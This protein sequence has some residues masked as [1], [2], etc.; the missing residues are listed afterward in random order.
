VHDQE[1]ARRAVADERWARLLEGEG[2][3][4][5]AAA[6][7]DQPIFA[8]QTAEQRARR[9]AVRLAQ[10]PRRLAALL[11]TLGLARQPRLEARGARIVVGSLDSKFR[12]L[13]PDAVV[14]PGGHDLLTENPAAIARLV[15]EAP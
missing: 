5:F 10:D 8:T 2:I 15:E 9:R 3:A 1:R 11:R 12:S 14:V 6:W 13:W 4:R 7:E